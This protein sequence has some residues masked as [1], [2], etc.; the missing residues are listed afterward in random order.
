MPDLPRIGEEFAGYWL[1]SRLGN[2]GMSVVFE[3][4]NW[5]LG[6][7][8]ALKI[9]APELAN[10]D[11]FRTRFLQESRI[12]AQLNHP[13]VVP[14]MDSG[15]SEGLLWIAMRYVA[16]HDIGRMIA[17]RGRLEPGIAVHLLSQAALALDAAHRRDLVHRD[18]K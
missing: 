15:A 14:I 18:V 2:G 5:R 1:R 11:T 16:G 13:H 10:D 8:V 7:V 3:A 9:I 6:N 4:E 17:E 12:A